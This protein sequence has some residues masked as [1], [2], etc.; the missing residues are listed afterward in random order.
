MKVWGGIGFQGVGQPEDVETGK[1]ECTMPPAPCIESEGDS[2]QVE[3]RI[4]P[5][6]RQWITRTDMSQTWIKKLVDK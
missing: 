3:P 5:F 4:P 6:F 1:K 2:P